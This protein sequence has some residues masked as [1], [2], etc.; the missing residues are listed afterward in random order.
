MDAGDVAGL[1]AAAGND[2]GAALAELQRASRHLE[3]PVPIDRKLQELLD[4]NLSA[5]AVLADLARFLAE[6]GEQH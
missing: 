5:S 3:L 4:A 1:I 2:P 6:T